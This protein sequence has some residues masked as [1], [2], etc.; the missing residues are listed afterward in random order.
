MGS[1]VTYR[2]VKIGKVSRMTVH[3][4]GLRVDLALEDEAE[5]PKDSEVFVHN[6]SAVG[7]QYLDFEPTT[8]EGPYLGEGDVITGDRAG[9]PV[10]E[11][12]LLENLGSMIRSIDKRDL[13]VVV[14]ELGLMFAGNAQ[15]LRSMITD[16]QL[17]VAEARANQAETIAL[18]DNA[19]PVL[20]TQ[21]A[22]GENIRAFSRD[23]AALTDTLRLSDKQ[24][25][26]I[27]D[28][29]APAA[30]EAEALVSGLRP[31][32]PEF[33]SNTTEVTRVM[34]ERRDG[35]EQLLVT[36]PRVISAGPTALL[37]DGPSGQKFGRVH[38]N[39]N[40]SPPACTDGYL[41]RNQW[42][43]TSDT[44]FVAY[45]PAQCNA[46]APVNM[47]GMKY[48]PPPAGGPAA[49]SYTGLITGTDR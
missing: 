32:L 5:V 36:F 15:P 34:A 19:Q 39:F 11:D 25:R 26:Q 17:L 49:P 9:L 45:Y 33:L 12:V 4:G 37:V 43:P 47:R 14:D 10:G 42:R 31:V 3:E 29:G 6:L 24:V 30:T 23:L 35:I 1:E 21:A 28:D 46:G 18:L 7:E 27:L 22:N 2:G 48:A 44:S 16:G 13:K 41:P 40:S 38:L 8:T 20:E